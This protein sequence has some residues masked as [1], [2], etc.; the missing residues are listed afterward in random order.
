MWLSRA[1]TLATWMGS[2]RW[3]EYRTTDSIHQYSDYRLL[4][5]NFIKVIA[6]FA[7]CLLTF[8]NNL[9]ATNLSQKFKY[10]VKLELNPCANLVTTNYSLPFRKWSNSQM[11]HSLSPF[12]W[13]LL[14]F[15][16]PRHTI[17]FESCWKLFLQNNRV[18]I[19][20]VRLNVA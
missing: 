9:L 19:V 17:F 1:K 3:T 11:R 10:S 7:Q 20:S 5:I 4:L 2:K 6:F 8:T 13:S 12:Y 14:Q 15:D 16:V 18:L